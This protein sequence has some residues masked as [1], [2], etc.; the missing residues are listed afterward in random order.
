LTAKTTWDLYEAEFI[1]LLGTASRQFRAT[2]VIFGDVFPE[3]HRQWAEGACHACQ[4]TA[5]EPLWAEA[6]NSLVR[7]FLS[8]RGEATI[9]TIRDD[10][11]DSSWLGRRLDEATIEELVALGVDPCGE[12]GEFHTFVTYFP[13]FDHKLEPKRGAIAQHGGCS[14]LDFTI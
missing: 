5:A 13:G 2:H 8:L 14:M 3:A 4:L 7:E 9:V 1:R 11:L 12:N 10:T 6:T